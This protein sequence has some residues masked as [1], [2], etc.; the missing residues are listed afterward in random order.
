MSETEH[1]AVTEYR[2]V[3]EGINCKVR[4]SMLLLV[5]AGGSRKKL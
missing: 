2:F 3:G 5:Q 4:Q 1:V